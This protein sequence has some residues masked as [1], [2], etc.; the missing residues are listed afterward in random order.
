MRRPAQATPGYVAVQV[1]QV[2]QGVQ[3]A[4]LEFTPV[5]FLSALCLTDG[6]TQRDNGGME[7]FHLWVNKL[8]S[9][10]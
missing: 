10:N 8:D 3:V 1:V 5:D 2:V 6:A 7:E 9:Q 4:A